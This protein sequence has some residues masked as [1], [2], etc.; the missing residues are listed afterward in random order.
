MTA[1]TTSTSAATNRTT[2]PS[3]AFG[4]FALVFGITFIVTYVLCVFKGWPLFTYHP[5]TDRF[6]WGYEL[7]RR[8]EGPAMYWYGWIALCTIVG[9]V[10]GTLATFLPDS[11]VRRIP[12]ALTWI[13]PIVALPLMLYTLMG[14]LTK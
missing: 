11:V 1:T 14:L 12:P 10:T 6:A 8:G 5:A 2:A 13:L 4:K 9:S 7:A 3:S